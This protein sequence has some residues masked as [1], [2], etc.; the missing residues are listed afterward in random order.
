MRPDDAADDAFDH[1]GGRQSLAQAGGQ[2][3]GPVG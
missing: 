1:L 3:G 2:G